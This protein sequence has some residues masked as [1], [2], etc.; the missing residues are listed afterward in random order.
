SHGGPRARAAPIRG[1]RCQDRPDAASWPCR[2][3]RRRAHLHWRREQAVL[4]IRLGADRV[5]VRGHRAENNWRI[6]GDRSDA[7]QLCAHHSHGRLHG[8]AS[9]AP[10]P[11]IFAAL[12]SIS[13][14]FPSK[15]CFAE[16]SMPDDKTNQREAHEDQAASAESPK[17]ESPNNSADP[18]AQL[19]VDLEALLNENAEMRDRLL[20]TM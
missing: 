6:G 14:L 13:R 9:W 12:R 10:C 1:S 15:T 5:A 7:A 19:G 16:P 4:A 3:R 2:A 17:A 8:K 18:G 11:L 20:R